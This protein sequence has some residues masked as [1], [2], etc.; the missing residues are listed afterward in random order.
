MIFVYSFTVDH[1]HDGDTIIGELD[2]GLGVY[3]RPISIR[4]GGVD[5][6][7]LNTE[8]GKAAA[9]AL[10]LL[11]PTGSQLVVHSPGWDKYSNRIDA[12]PVLNAGGTDVIEAGLLDGWLR[13]WMGTGPRPW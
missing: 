7:E 10:M 5:A 2:M 6:A 11:A 1:V 4:L 8:Q 9:R 13:P 3:Q 12:R